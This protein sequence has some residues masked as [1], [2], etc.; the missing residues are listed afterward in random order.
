[1]KPS[2]KTLESAA[3]SLWEDERLR[4]NLTD[5][6]AK[7]ILDWAVKLM[8]AR[9]RPATSDAN[10]PKMVNP[11]DLDRMRH[12]VVTINSV[13]HKPGD[14]ALPEVIAEVIPAMTCGK[15]LTREEVLGLLTVIADA[16]LEM[17]TGAK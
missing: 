12:L 1:M 10:A 14:L 15:P 16:V 4:S 6:E 11:G 2:G 17:R 13:A 8:E 7:Q 9:A 5:T 3:E